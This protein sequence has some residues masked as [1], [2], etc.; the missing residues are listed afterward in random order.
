MKVG[1]LV[2]L[3]WGSVPELECVKPTEWFAQSVRRVTPLIFLEW[4]GNGL[5]EEGWATLLHP[6][7]SKK[8][9][10]CDYFTRLIR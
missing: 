7:G 5:I 6:D 3:N 1:D 4:A 10:H 9:V 8:V 2:S